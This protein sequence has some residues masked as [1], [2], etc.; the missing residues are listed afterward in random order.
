MNK[1]SLSDSQL[2]CLRYLLGQYKDEHSQTSRRI[3]D[4]CPGTVPHAPPPE[5]AIDAL[6]RDG[7]ACFSTVPPREPTFIKSDQV[8]LTRFA[9]CAAGLLQSL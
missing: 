9:S 2:E 8:Q 5:F 7:G 3:L 6:A 4:S 1:M